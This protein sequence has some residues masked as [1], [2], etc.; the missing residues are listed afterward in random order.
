MVRLFNKSLS[1][2]NCGKK[3]PKIAPMSI[4]VPNKEKTVS[5]KRKRIMNPLNAIEMGMAI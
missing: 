1:Y 3:K 5:I 4:R 2:L